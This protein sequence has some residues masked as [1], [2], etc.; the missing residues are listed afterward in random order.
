MRLLHENGAKTKVGKGHFGNAIQAASY[1]GRE[2]FV[3]YLLRAG[4][5]VNDLAGKYG[6]PLACAVY[7]GHKKIVDMLL[8]MRADMNQDIGAFGS[9]LHLAC[10]WGHEGI[11]IALL[12]AGANLGAVDHSGRIPLHDA[13]SKGQKHLLPKLIQLSEDPRAMDDNGWTPLDEAN[14]RGRTDIEGIFANFG[15]FPWQIPKG[16]ILPS[17]DRKTLIKSALELAFH[18]MRRDESWLEYA[19][20]NL[21]YSFFYLSK[22]DI[23][24]RACQE[25]SERWQYR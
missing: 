16:C 15:V 9:A 10:I 1:A 18:D 7:K 3:K 23:A 21:R 8:E 24:H 20:P 11:L 25:I 13:V 19:L 14:W 2:K 5:N 12:N 17:K 4:E 6:S 22:N